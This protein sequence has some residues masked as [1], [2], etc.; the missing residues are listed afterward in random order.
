MGENSSVSWTAHSFNAWI[1]CEKIAPG[2]TNCYAAALETRYNV[3]WGS[4]Q[5]GGT[6]RH[7]HAEVSPCPRR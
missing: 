3:N 1:G 4:E 5:A 7:V 6:R 2:C